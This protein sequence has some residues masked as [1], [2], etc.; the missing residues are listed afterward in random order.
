M[1]Y[2]LGLWLLI[3]S[4]CK[5]N[6]Y[7][8]DTKIADIQNDIHKSFFDKTYSDKAEFYTKMEKAISENIRMG[9]LII[10]AAKNTTID[11]ID[12][13]QFKECVFFEVWNIKNPQSAS[14][15]LAAK[16]CQTLFTLEYNKDIK[17]YDPSFVMANFKDL[18]TAE[19]ILA[20]KAI[21]E[22]LSKSFDS[23]DIKSYKFIDGKYQILNNG[24][25]IYIIQTFKAKDA[26]LGD[27]TQNA[28]VVLTNKGNVARIDLNQNK[29]FNL[30]Y[31]N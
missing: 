7:N 26:I 6:E 30:T 1:K 28:H 13:S 5:E 9:D 2:I 11:K 18:K 8:T 25:Y 19:N 4:G 17:Y 23:T 3:L 31:I 20:E 29:N 10:Q 15:D 16:R 24:K 22:E 14:Y 21:K 12:P 27:Y